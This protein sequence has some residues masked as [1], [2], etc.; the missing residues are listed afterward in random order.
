MSRP[1]PGLVGGPI[2]AAPLMSR[3]IPGLVGGPIAAGPKTPW[4]R[5]VYGLHQGAWRPTTPS[6]QLP[7]HVLALAKRGVCG[8]PG[9]TAHSSTHCVGVE[10]PKGTATAGVIGVIATQALTCRKP[11]QTLRHHDAGRAADCWS[12]RG[13]GGPTRFHTPTLT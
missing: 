1:I 13:G 9:L 6:C 12:P 8:L 3:P 11:E 10:V 2:A 5:R 7:G 4:E